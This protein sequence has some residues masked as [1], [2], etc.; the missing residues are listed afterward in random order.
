ML[1]K[2]HQRSSRFCSDL[3]FFVELVFYQR[4][5][6][7]R[8][9]VTVWWA[10]RKY[11]CSAWLRHELL[12]GAITIF[13]ATPRKRNQVFI[14]SMFLISAVTTA[15]AA[16]LWTRS[17]KRGVALYVLALWMEFGVGWGYCQTVSQPSG[18][19]LLVRQCSDYPPWSLVVCSLC[20]G[21]LVPL[22]HRCLMQASVTL[23]TMVIDVC[24][25]CNSQSNI[26][27]PE[28][29]GCY[30]EFHA[31]VKKAIGC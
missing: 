11:E 26:S 27:G 29:Y 15:A 4:F 8:L 7:F 30:D 13:C 28:I 6:C 24:V 22:E 2:P 25:W 16:L 10:Q 31:T 14:F 18:W 3:Q 1:V 20:W 17:I 12:H 19:Y 23:E 5:H 21:Q 9:K